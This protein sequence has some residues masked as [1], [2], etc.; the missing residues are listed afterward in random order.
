MTKSILTAL[1]VMFALSVPAYAAMHAAQKGSI[2]QEEP[3]AEPQQPS[4][5]EQPSGGGGGGD[6]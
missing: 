6:D 3:S 1:A 5:D 4:G 2:Y